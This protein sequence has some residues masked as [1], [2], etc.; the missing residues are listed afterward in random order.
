MREFLFFM[1]GFVFAIVATVVGLY[2]IGKH[3]MK[4][5]QKWE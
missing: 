1:G 4:K 3:E 2:L 5:V